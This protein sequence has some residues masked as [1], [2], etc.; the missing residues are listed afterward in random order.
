MNIIIIGDGKVGYTIAEHLAKEDHNITIIDNNEEALK[1]ADDTLDVMCIKGNGARKS[2][3]LEAGIETADILIAVTSRDEMNMVCCLM[4]KKICDIRTVA[5]IRDPEYYE[6]FSDLQ[7]NVGID[8]VINPEYAAALEIANILQF[9]S[10]MNIEP[11]FGGRV[12]MVEFRVQKGDMLDGLKLFQLGS[13]WPENTLVLAV[14]RRQEVYIPGGDFEFQEGD[15]LFVMG[16]IRSLGEMFRR[17]N[18]YLQKVDS[19]MIAGG[20]RTAYYLTKIIERLNISVKIIEISNKKCQKLSEDLPHAMIIEGDGTDREVLEAENVE[21]VDA[22]ITMTGRDEENLITAMYAVER[23]VDKVIAMTTRVNLPSIINK[24]GLDSVVSPKLVTASYIIGYVR[25]MQNSEGGIV[26]SLYK[27]VDGKAEIISF[28]ANDTAKVLNLPL[29][30]LKLKKEVLIACIQHGSNII[31]PHGNEQIQ[32]GDKVLVVT[33]DDTLILS[34]DAI[35][36]D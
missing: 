35:V 7:Q 14:E 8:V 32:E 2:V 18:R 33:K 25:G 21:D 9:P 24:L 13:K 36:A 16:Q 34:L 31:V 30:E 5:R 12:R 17:M 23:G 11:F 20:G 22:F 15:K 1:K 4:A 10:A 26:E 27:I 6:E 28:I 3:L 19:V 29:R